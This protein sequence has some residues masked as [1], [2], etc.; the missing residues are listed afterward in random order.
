MALSKVKWGGEDILAGIEAEWDDDGDSDYAPYEGPRPP[1]GVYTWQV[2]M[3]KAESNN[4]NPQIIVHMTLVPRLPEHKRF[5]GYYCRDY[6]TFTP[7]TGF[8][9]APFLKVLG[10]TARQFWDSTGV[11]Q[12]GVI[13]QIGK[14]KFGD[15]LLLVCGIRPDTKGNPD[16]EQVRYIRQAT[17]DLPSGG[18]D[19]L[20]DE[21]AGSKKPTPF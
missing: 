21:D 5:E 6:L 12:D 19:E 3:N 8:R 11:D 20:V 15:D 4:G 16:Y 13:K 9:T 7:K 2:R 10:V 17:D 18:D 1:R 14:K